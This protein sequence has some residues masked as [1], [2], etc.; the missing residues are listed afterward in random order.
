MV[1]PL[2]SP[3]SRR[4]TPPKEPP[5]GTGRFGAGIDGSANGGIFLSS[6]RFSLS[7]G[8]ALPE[9]LGQRWREVSGID[10]LDGIGSTEM[11][12][13]FVSNKPGAIRYGWKRMQAEHWDALAAR[14]RVQR[15]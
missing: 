11:L 2:P 5:R 6:V 4:R 10:V 13:T 8:E 12:Q 1:H 9:M 3:A 14:L 7:A 15:A